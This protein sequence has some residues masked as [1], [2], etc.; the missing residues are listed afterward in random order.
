MPHSPLDISNNLAGR[1]FVPASVESFR[2]EPQLD[3]E[4]VRIVL[5]LDFATLFLPQLDE[6]GFV[7]AHDPDRHSRLA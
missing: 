1:A 6:C 5:R 2:C 7:L 4:V 3:N